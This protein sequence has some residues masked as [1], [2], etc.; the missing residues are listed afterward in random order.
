MGYGRR[1]VCTVAALL[2]LLSG[3]LPTASAAPGT[4]SLEAGLPVRAAGQADFSAPGGSLF[5][6]DVGEEL[7]WVLQAHELDVKVVENWREVSDSQLPNPELHRGSRVAGEWTLTG[8]EMVVRDRL[9]GFQTFAWTEQGT[10]WGHAGQPVPMS[11]DQPHWRLEP[12]LRL[13]R[14]SSP[15]IVE[16]P[17]PQE[18]SLG[19]DRIHHEPFSHEVP[20]GGFALTAPDATFALSGDF[21]GYLFGANAVAMHTD[22]THAMRLTHDEERRDGN[23]YVVGVGWTGPGTHSEHVVR[24]VEFEAR[25]A[26]L[27]LAGATTGAMMHAPEWGLDLEGHLQVPR[28]HGS[29][30]FAMDEGDKTWIANDEAVVLS[31]M[32]SAAIFAGKE[33]DQAR[34]EGMGELAYV[35]SGPREVWPMVGTIASVAGV[36]VA[37][38]VVLGVIQWLTATPAFPLFSRLETGKVLSHPLR[39]RLFTTVRQ[40]PGVSP[41]ELVTVHGAGWSTVVYHLR[42]L[43]QHGLVTGVRD[44]RHRRFFDSTSGRWANGRKTI[45]ATLLNP[46]SARVACLVKNEPGV[47]QR[48]LAERMELA[49]SSVNWHVRRLAKVG[50]VARVRRPPGIELQPGEAWDALEQAQAV[51]FVVAVAAGDET[52]CL[53]GEDDPLS[54]EDG[55]LKAKGNGSQ[56]GARAGSA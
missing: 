40:R 13:D 8:V 22:G 50:L 54:D 49:P 32:M 15:L 4:F 55:P 39:G 45:L 26:T 25:N 7:E 43:E 14:L 46:T 18:R 34:L 37:M 35:A 17:V 53:P 16:S 38:A 10:A 33:S 28:A 41:Q 3:S 6:E 42:V 1:T 20:E 44:G 51:D 56:N 47:A 12:D 36:M 11:A 29:L 9:E 27:S 31:G 5:A 2:I 24:H 19:A 52:F 21:S 23:V 48:E 30:T